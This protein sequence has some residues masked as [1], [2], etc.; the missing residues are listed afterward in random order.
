VNAKKIAVRHHLLN[1][2]GKDSPSHDYSTRAVAATYC[3]AEVKD[4]KMYVN[5]YVDLFGSNFQPPMAAGTDRTDAEF[6]APG[7]N[8]RRPS[9]C[10][11]L[12]KVRPAGEPCENQSVTRRDDVSG[13]GPDV[14][15]PQ[16]FKGTTK[17]D[18][19]VAGWVD[20]LG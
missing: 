14:S 18:F 11:R 1:F 17:V 16:V 4:A 15:T 5:F 10:A 9:D 7:P 6:G 2:L 8:G 19:S 12:H 3:V 13:L 20:T